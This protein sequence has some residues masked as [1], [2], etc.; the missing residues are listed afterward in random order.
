MRRPAA[1][2]TESLK[3]R[4]SGVESRPLRPVP[5]GNFARLQGGYAKTQ[6]RAADKLQR[7]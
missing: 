4:V 5:S 3:G 1:Q 7:V 6:K 2:P